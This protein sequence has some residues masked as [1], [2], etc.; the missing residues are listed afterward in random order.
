MN[1]DGL[2]PCTSLLSASSVVAGTSVAAA[3]A[4]TD[5]LPASIRAMAPSVPGFGAIHWSALRP[6]SERRGPI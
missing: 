6:V 5:I 4:A 1:S 2:T 3:A